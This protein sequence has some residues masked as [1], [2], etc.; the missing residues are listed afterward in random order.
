MRFSIYFESRFFFVYTKIRK[1]IGDANF[2]AASPIYV[3]VV[4]G[5]L[6]DLNTISLVP[7]R[8]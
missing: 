3:C 8:R 2:C 4:Y 1:K 7:V 6:K 5:L